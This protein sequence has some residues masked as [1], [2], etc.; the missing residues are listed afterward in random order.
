LLDKTVRKD[1]FPFQD[2][3]PPRRER[4][5]SMLSEEERGKAKESATKEVEGGRKR[6]SKENVERDPGIEVRDVPWRRDPRERL[7]AIS[8]DAGAKPRRE[9]RTERRKE[10]GELSVRTCLS[11]R[12]ENEPRKIFPSSFP[13]RFHSS[14]GSTSR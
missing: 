9:R 5:L 3:P 14:A 2:E 6:A 8:T 1:E 4:R 10:S 12:R 7:L 13:L 11:C